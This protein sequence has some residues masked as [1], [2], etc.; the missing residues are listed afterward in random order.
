[1]PPAFFD[2]KDLEYLVILLYVN[3]NLI[4]LFSERRFGI[5]IPF[6]EGGSILTEGLIRAARDRITSAR[7][8][9]VLTGA[10]ISADSGV[11]TFRGEGGLWKRFRAEELA[12]P[13]AFESHPEIVWEWYHWRRKMISEK[14]PNPGHE[15][16]VLLENARPNFTLITQNVDGLHTLAGSRRVIELH[17]SLWR[18]RCMQCNRITENR[19]L[20]LPLL[21]DCDGCHSLL[22]P[23]VVWFGEAI[24]PIHLQKSLE[25][26]RGSD[27]F[28]VIGTSGVVQPAASFALF[29]KEQGAFTI[30][31]NTV[32]SEIADPNLLLIGRAAEVVP[33]IIDGIH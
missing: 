21:P 20:D 16:L 23:D 27:V 24:N 10:G 30:E 17:G 31:I 6:H 26:C 33:Q 22:R 9:T 1:L 5:L 15:A 7:S 12:T 32:A 3:G 11:P 28:L 25:A 8:I 14:R 13:E 2:P 18:M 4:L 29:A 19:S